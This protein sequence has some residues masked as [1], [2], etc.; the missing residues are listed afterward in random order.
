MDTRPPGQ[1][2]REAL[3]SGD[4]ALVEAELAR[5]EASVRSL[6]VY[7]VEWITSLLSFVGRELGDDGV[8]RSLRAF[9]DD[10]VLPR[11]GQ[12]GEWEALP[13]AVRASVI[14]RAMLAN[15]GSV[16]V[17]EDEDGL[18][19]SFRCGSGGRLIDEGRY[20]SDGGPYLTLT[21]PSP[22]TAGLVGL[23]VYCS[24]CPVHNELLELERGGVP[25]SVEEPS[26]GPGGLCVHRV[27]HDARAMDPAVWTRVGLEPPHV[28]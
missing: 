15:G 22:L 10:F 25:M 23:P 5:W 7:S 2:L 1:R 13:A 8:E 9:G 20:D 17:T 26:P 16:D 4:A 19:L 6:Q 21:G 3:A 11:R 14:A 27:P 12:P 28:R 24:H 18:T